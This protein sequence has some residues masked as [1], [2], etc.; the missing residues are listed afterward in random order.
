MPRHVLGS[1]EG[2]HALDDLLR[3]EA[4]ELV[5]VAPHDDAVLRLLV[6]VRHVHVKH[7][8]AVRAVGAAEEDLHVHAN[9][10]GRLGAVTG[11]KVQAGINPTSCFSRAAETKCQQWTMPAVQFSKASGAGRCAPAC[12]PPRQ[13]VQ[14]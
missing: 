14:A 7:V 12:P 6:V 3:L 2:Q 10:Q 13:S 9:Q 8:A 11:L 5:V 1:E 4:G